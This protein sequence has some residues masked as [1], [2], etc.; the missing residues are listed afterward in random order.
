MIILI[1]PLPPPVHGASLINQHVR[2]WLIRQH[3]PV[4][5]CSTL[6]ASGTRG[7]R[8]LLGRIG[9]YL[10]CCKTI[11]SAHAVDDRSAVYI[12]LSGGFGLIYD[13]AV[14]LAARIKGYEIVFHHHA[15]SYI[16]KPSPVLK[17]IVR[18]AGSKQT[19][20]ALCPTMALG[21]HKIYGAQLR[22]VIISNLIFFDL[23]GVRRR[24]P[25]RSLA[26]LG[27]LS[28]ISLAKGIDRFLDLLTLLRSRGSRLRAFIAGPFD[29]AQVRD[30]VE[31][32]IHQ[33]GGVEYCG[34]VYGEEKS[35]F[36]AS[37]DLLVFPSR[38]HNE[39]QPLVVFEAQAA[40]VPVAASQRGCLCEMLDRDPALRLDSTAS[41][42][43]V[44]ADQILEWEQE[45][46]SFGKT[47]RRARESF[48]AISDAC[49][50][51]AA[52]F[53]NL[54]NAYR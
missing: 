6:P 34:P 19:H 29:D 37:L 39:A 32:R 18:A 21:L 20:I 26:V 16:N 40:G 17:A 51:D 14:T 9:A 30:L 53:D 3:V 43:T 22:I 7:Y 47:A 11:L 50:A 23:A 49:A 15:F 35:A 42:L 41:D 38:Y 28:N 2:D 33:I 4:L 27:Y 48:R 46:E 12:T 36:L 8:Y 54:V 44:L 45:P 10:R 25:G 13:F 52:R 24:D 5:A 1:G 31:R